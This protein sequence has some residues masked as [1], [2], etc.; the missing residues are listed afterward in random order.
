MARRGATVVR[1][2]RKRK[3]DTGLP[4]RV[5]TRGASYYFVD[6]DGKWHRLCKIAEGEAAM[7]RCLAEFK[8]ESQAEP[9]M[10][11]VFRRYRAE[12]LP[13]KAPSTAKM[14]ARQLDQLED[15]F[16][17]MDPPAIRPH[18]IAQFHDLR[19]QVAPVSANRELALLSHLMRFA[20]RMGKVPSGVNPCS[21]IQ[22]H[23]EEARDRYVEHDEYNAVW[24]RA[25]AH[26]RVLMDLA[27]LTG[28]RQADLVNL[29]RAKLKTDGIHFRQ[30][31]SVR[32]GKVARK[33]IIEYSDAMRS[34]LQAAGDL[35]SV[36]SLYVISQPNGQK[37]TSS[38]V[39]TAWQRLMREC[40]VEGIVSERFTFHD[41]RAK[42]GSDDDDGRLLGHMSEATRRRV[43]RRK[44]EKFKPV[45]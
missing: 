13:R 29:R 2:G 21:T 23:T 28:Q 17:A 20:I 9:G 11:E 33:I 8:D 4:K 30:A 34:V 22:R 7:H 36:I 26:L 32:K 41:I 43:Y 44:P 38:G 24:Q 1:M 10:R 25:P 37:Y 6:Y 31:K 14:Q 42:A 18:H 39:Q 40:L 3:H 45:L 5:Y 19:G 12:I 16:G 35:S 15:V 27:Y